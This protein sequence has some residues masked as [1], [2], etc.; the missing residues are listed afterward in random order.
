MRVLLLGTGVQPV[1]PP[2]Y[3]AVEQI[4]SEYADAL[5][6]AGQ[7]VQI[8]NEVRRG[9]MSDE[10][11]FAWG[12]PRRLRSERFD[13]LHAST[14]VVANRLAAAGLPYVYTTHS[15]HWF[16]RPNWTHRW[17]FWL[18]RRAVRRAQ[19]DIALTSALEREIRLAFGTHPRPLVHVIPF[20]VD[21]ERFRPDEGRRTGLRA[22]GV[23]VVLP[24]KR[25]EI[26]ARALRGSGVHFTIAGPMPDRRYAESVQRAGDE[27][28]LL[29]NLPSTELPR[30]YSESDVL[31]HPSSVEV[32]PRSVVEA[33]ASGLPVVGTDPVRPC[34]A[35]GVTGY[36][37][38]YSGGTD[39][40]VGGFREKTL[41]LLGD[42]GVRRTMGRAA[43]A[44]AER[45]F[46]WTRVVA[47]HL[48]VYE[49]LTGPT[50]T[51]PESRP[52]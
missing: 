40:L 42:D 32:L 30:L 9:R 4:L 5:R 3:G 28:T 1:P 21:L 44:E 45:E 46:S 23:G 2:G 50:T 13:I 11:R 18:E 6:R 29:G 31:L 48:R 36:V 17:G 52:A 49:R 25:W 43:R 22:L 35:D 19:V 7:N 15:R 24:F 37:V 39:R 47:E 16:W 38:P 34:V 20:G 14:P 8:V 27:V 51:Q 33:L 41:G 10:Y 26:A 12:L